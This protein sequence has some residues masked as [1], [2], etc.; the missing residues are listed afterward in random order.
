MLGTRK[1]FTLIELFV[2]IAIIAILAAILFPVFARA[3]ENARR[4]SCQS[5]LKQLSLGVMQYS[6]D[7]DEFL[8]SVRY[9]W[10][11]ASGPATAW[12]GSYNSGTGGWATGWPDL[13][14]PYIK[15]NQVMHCPS[16]KFAG[17]YASATRPIGLTS[18]GMN[19]CL[20][21]TA[22]GTATACVSNHNTQN[23]SNPRASGI[24]QSAIVQSS[25]VILLAD[26]LKF[27]PQYSGFT[28]LPAVRGS[29][30]FYWMGPALEEAYTSGN[31]YGSYYQSYINAGY[32]ENNYVFPGEQNGRHFGGAN[33][34]YVDGHVKF[35]KSGTRGVMWYEDGDDS[36]RYWAPGFSG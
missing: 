33:I 10:A 27:S 9:P 22:P 18:Y 26:I 23:W 4:A 5:N 21:Q 11:D 16:D 6:Q 24:S 36:S 28:M 7:Y 14:Q 31:T 32:N 2:V 30:P 3:R 29:H 35:A 1:A 17:R 13:I 15:S 8:P 19:H 20:N 34:A 25:R 12:Q